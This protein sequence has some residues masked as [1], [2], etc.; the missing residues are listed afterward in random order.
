MTYEI[1]VSKGIET[2]YIEAE[3]SIEAMKIANEKYNDKNFEY[4]T[5]SEYEEAPITLD[6]FIDDL[7][8]YYAKGETD[9][10]ELIDAIKKQKER[11]YI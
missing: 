7:G 4:K 8:Y 3:D 10:I 9:L 11:I 6:A 2:Y 5:V 1:T